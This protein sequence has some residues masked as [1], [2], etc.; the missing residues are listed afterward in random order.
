MNDYRESSP[1]RARMFIALALSSSGC[2]A[3]AAPPEPEKASEE[4]GAEELLSAPSIS[5]DGNYLKRTLAR[6]ARFN[7]SNG[8]IFGNDGAIYMASVLS[9]SIF[10]IDAET[11]EILQIF[12]PAEGVETP[13]DVA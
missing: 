8:L 9:R 4:F 5:S 10:K 7:A 2:G 12:G 3:A 11:G 1:V 13:D 6:G